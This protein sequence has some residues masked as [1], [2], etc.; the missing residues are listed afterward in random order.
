MAVDRTAAKETHP[1]RL[2]RPIFMVK[3]LSGGKGEGPNRKAIA[4]WPLLYTG[5][6][7]KCQHPPEIPHPNGQRSLHSCKLCL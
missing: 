3:T 5:M 1:T 6:W 4:T 2:E 7:P